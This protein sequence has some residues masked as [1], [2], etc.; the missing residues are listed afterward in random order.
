MSWTVRTPLN[1]AVINNNLLSSASLCISSKNYQH[2]W[3]RVFFSKRLWSTLLHLA[4]KNCIAPKIPIL[5]FQKLLKY[6]KTPTFVFWKYWERHEV[7]SEKGDNKILVPLFLCTNQPLNIMPSSNVVSCL[8][9][10]N[11][12]IASASWLFN[13]WKLTNLDYVQHCWWL[14]SNTVHTKYYIIK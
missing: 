3:E 5:L 12:K 13:T 14:S 9:E 7:F 4:I 11:F 8:L 1:L 6:G 2:T 10:N